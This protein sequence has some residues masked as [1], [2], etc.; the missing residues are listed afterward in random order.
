M[1][2]P[3]R[4]LTWS[5]FQHVSSSWSNRCFFPNCRVLRF[6]T[7]LTLETPKSA[8]SSPSCSTNPQVYPPRT[9]P[10]AEG[11]EHCPPRAG[12]SPANCLCTNQRVGHL[13]STRPRRTQSWAQPG[14]ES[15]GQ[16]S[17]S[18][19]TL[20]TTESA[21]PHLQHRTSTITTLFTAVPNVASITPLQKKKMG[22][23]GKPPMA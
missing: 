4:C 15:W 6:S 12:L 14:T 19:V 5:E 1:K 20:F 9:Q 23:S 10:L 2:G 17:H 22:I 7:E 21:R 18:S 11:P 16:C 8:S 13:S 3:G